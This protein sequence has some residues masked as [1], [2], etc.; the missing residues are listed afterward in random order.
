[1]EGVE[2]EIT[3]GLVKNIDVVFV[4]IEDDVKRI[5]TKNRWRFKDF[6][7]VYRLASEMTAKTLMKRHLASVKRFYECNDTDM[8]VQWI[9][10]RI[11]SNM[12]NVGFDSRYKKNNSIELKELYEM[13]TPRTL[14]IET[15]IVFDDLYKV[16]KPILLRGL[17]KVWEDAQEDFDFDEIDFEELCEK[18]GFTVSEVMGETILLKAEQTAGGHRQLVLFFD[19]ND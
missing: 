14:D 13:L 15:L 10:R 11:I 8:A 19:P 16:D 7:D 4:S 12:R 18:F 2:L 9:I 3:D 1:M 5:V 6:D 17:R